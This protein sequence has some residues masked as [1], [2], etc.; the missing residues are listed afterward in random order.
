[1]A[2]KIVVHHLSKEFRAQN[3]ALPVLEDVGFTVAEGEFV[4]LVGPSG[5]GKTTLL[6][7]IAGFERPDRG[8]V[9]ING[10]P[11]SSPNP[12][13]IVISQLGSVFP[14]LTVERNLTFGLNGM[15]EPERRRLAEHYVSLVGLRG[16]EKSFPYELSGGMLK[17]VELARALAVKP[18]ILYM[19]EPLAS[20]D[21]LT[22]FRMRLELLQIL[23][24]ERYTTLLV[25]H[26][27]EEA[28]H[29]AHRV[30]V[31]SARPASIQSVVEV[32]F[33]HPR[34]LSS[35]PFME[36]KEQILRELGVQDGSI[37]PK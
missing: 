23:A 7:I 15:S 11:V 14:W 9:I 26:D 28:I 21:A 33:P 8:Q 10:E 30:L 31:L 36:L 2:D 6:N 27:V 29:L 19:D 3:S 20:L 12:R 32:P 25:T 1:M 13:N 18:D 17:R 34:K 4:A 24:E 16:F 35:A 22:R 37:L 5:C